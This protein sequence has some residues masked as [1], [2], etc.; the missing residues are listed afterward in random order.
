MLNLI[1][2]RTLVEVLRIGSF[3][4]AGNRLG[5]TA[6]AVSQQMSL[7]ERETGIQLFVRSARSAHPTESAHAMGQHAQK[8]LRDADGLV[9]AVSATVH[10]S[11]RE[12][13]VGV[14]PSAALFILAELLESAQWT[15][16]G[17]QLKATIG[18]PSTTVPRLRAGGELDLALV[19]QVGEVGLVLPN[20]VTRHWLGDDPFCVVVPTAWGLS[21]GSRV[22]IDE[23]A[24]KPWLVHLRGSSDANV[25]ESTLSNAG[26][27][28]RVVASS[29]DFNVTLRLI[30]AGHGMAL[31]PQLTLAT[32][33]PGLT[34]IH[35]PEL[36][37]SRKLIALSAEAAPVESTRE[38]LRIAGAVTRQPS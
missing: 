6:S 4:G 14:F 3:S 20:G 31:V 29:D 15:D 34:V 10:G 36:A 23:L 7:L 25:V 9:T 19:Y 22:A 38:F 24:N 5:Y 13:R 12:L 16:L 30:A 26:L 8:L 21:E 28:P 2:L 1:H 35:V 37:L 18:E 11:A 27:H 17:I 32:R 33:P